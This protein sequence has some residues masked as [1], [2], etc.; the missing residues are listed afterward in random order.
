M[1]KTAYYTI[2]EDLRTRIEEGKYTKG[3]KLP[4]KRT[5]AS[6]Y[7]VSLVT[8]EHALELLLEEGYI[9]SR[10]R[11]GYEVIYEPDSFFSV[12]NEENMHQ[13]HSVEKDEESFP[14]SVL[15]RAMRKVL[16]E[17]DEELLNR[18]EN[19]G[20]YE[21]REAIARY[22]GRSRD[23]FVS[24]DQIVIGAGA[25]YLY[26]LIPVLLGRKKIYGL[27][28]PGYAKIGLIYRSMGIHVDPLKMGE[29]GIE[30]TELERTDARILHVTPFHSYPTGVTADKEKR[31]EYIQW[32]DEKKAIIVEDDFES[33]FAP[34]IRQ[35]HT[36]F[37]MEP[38]HTVLYLNTFTR[39]IASAIRIGYMVLPESLTDRYMRYLSY[40][41][42]TVSTFDQLTDAELL[43]SGAFERH[44]HKVRNLRKNHQ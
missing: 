1:K 11:S 21:L 31:K 17:Y 8:V 26:T 12:G 7:H 37:S 9:V 3:D 38:D 39:T 32:A 36:L 24:P 13:S 23:L 15:A 20:C 14:Y 19:T 16:S 2:Y 18:R 25:E 33:E 34:D 27:E 5:T 22:L 40:R 35:E 43:N 6:L 28:D 30:S 29:N 4:S 10:E 42:C 41:A 44:L